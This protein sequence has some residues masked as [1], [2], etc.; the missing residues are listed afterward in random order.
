MNDTMTWYVQHMAELDLECAFS[1]GDK[2]LIDESV[3]VSLDYLPDVAEAL[4]SGTRIGTITNRI[5]SRYNG[6]VEP[7]YVVILDNCRVG[8][9]QYVES[10][11]SLVDSVEVVELDAAIAEAE[12]HVASLKKIRDRISK[13]IKKIA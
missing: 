10:E 5:K 12:A 6:D 8:N 3:I 9:V 13:R 11:L 1:E 4:R 7:R 2:V